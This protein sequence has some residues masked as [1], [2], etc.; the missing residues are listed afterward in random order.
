MKFRV[1]FPDPRGDRHR[2]RRE[3]RGRYYGNGDNEREKR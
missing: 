1:G 2:Q 3:P